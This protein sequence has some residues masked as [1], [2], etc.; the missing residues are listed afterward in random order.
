MDGR[1]KNVKLLVTEMPTAPPALNGQ[2]S[3]TGVVGDNG[4]CVLHLNITLP[5][6]C[7]HQNVMK[8]RPLADPFLLSPHTFLE[9]ISAQGSH[10]M[11]RKDVLHHL[12]LVLK[13][14]KLVQSESKLSRVLRL[15]PQ[16]VRA[17]LFQAHDV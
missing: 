11:Q 9:F 13:S 17:T 16:C 6:I 2:D 10:V 3:Y 14:Q 5:L 8:I 1:V 4:S 7:Q 15:H 12:N